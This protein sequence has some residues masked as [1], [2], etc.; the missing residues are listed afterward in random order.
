MIPWRL[1]WCFYNEM[2]RVYAMERLSECQ[3]ITHG[4]GMAMG[5]EG[6]KMTTLRTF[7]LAFPYLSDEDLERGG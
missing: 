6:S 7:R 1:F 5:A 4:I 3:A 2:P